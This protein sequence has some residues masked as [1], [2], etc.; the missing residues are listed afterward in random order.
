[1]PANQAPYSAPKKDWAPRLGF[2]YDPF[3][4]GKMVVHG[5]GG[6]FYMPMQ[7]GFGLT[8]NIPA[9]A[10]YNVNVFQAIFATPPFSIAYPSPNPPLI[11]GTQNVS[12]FPQ[13]PRDP[14]ST[15]WLF[16]IQQE[17]APSTVLTVNYTGNK[18]Q[19]MQAGISFAAINVNPSN[20]NINL[21]NRPYSGF[22]NE[23]VD[24]DEL[25]SN[26]NALQVQLKRNAGRLNL[27]GNY[28]W[29]HEIDDLVNVFSGWSNPFNPNLDRGSGDWDVR[30]NF[31]ASA[32]Y[33]LPDLKGSNSLTRGILG[34]WQASTILQT[35]SGLP[36]NIQVISGFFGTPLRPDFVP[37]QPLW[38][39]GHSW[40]NTSYNPAAFQLPSNFEGVWGHDIG[41]V[42][43]NGLRAPAF[44][45]WDMSGAK[46]F[47]V[48]ERVNVQF[49]ADFFNILNHPNFTNP[50][51]GICSSITYTGPPNPT[52]TCVPNTNF[53]R[54]SQTIA[55]VAGG[56][57]GNGTARQ[58]QFSLKLMF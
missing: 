16:G 2:A 8:S 46:S 15:N 43:R 38:L 55:D 54:S 39:A 25:Y 51:G 48:T 50:D 22:A 7:F 28:T 35:R 56:A 29:S 57:I 42:G 12:A 24:A 26:Y 10:S 36:E 5:Y 34:G 41:N 21:P 47:P 44:F 58:A 37:G 19:H 30:H 33:R 52:G 49:R 6:L 31:T 53:G 20:P 23:N 14:Y 3:G 17:V 1:L 4:R 9:L 32:V 45:Q 13:H 11:A 18:T 40:P 27:E